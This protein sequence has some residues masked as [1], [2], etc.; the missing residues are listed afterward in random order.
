MDEG[1]PRKWEGEEGE[2]VG[3]E[4]VV[5][6]MEGEVGEGV[7]LSA[8]TGEVLPEVVGGEVG[9]CFWVITAVVEDEVVVAARLHP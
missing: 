7:V 3:T 6:L 5:V 2:L 8:V 4:A 9:A 1:G